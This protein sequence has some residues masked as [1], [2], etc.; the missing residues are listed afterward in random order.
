MIRLPVFGKD[1]L[2]HA[3]SRVIS[4]GV[5]TL[6]WFIFI[7]C[8]IYIGP[9]KNDNVK[10]EVV[11]LMLSPEDHY[12]PNIT[13][14]MIDK[15]GGKAGSEA[16]MAGSEADMAQN[17]PAQERLPAVEQ[18]APVEIPVSNPVQKQ[19][20]PAPV[21]TNNAQKSPAS[22]AKQPVLVP[23]SSAVSQTTSTTSAKT[24]DYAN[25]VD[26]ML[27]TQTANT[28]PKDYSNVDWDAMFGDSSNA[29]TSQ[30]VATTKVQSQNSVSG[31]AATT[32]SPSNPTASSS[33]GT[34][35]SGATNNTASSSTLN[36]LS[37]MA[38]S[39]AAAGSNSSDSSTANA[40][41]SSS[42]KT[43]TGGP[44]EFNDGASRSLKS[45]LKITFS[46]EASKAI[47]ENRD[48]VISFYINEAGNVYNI[49][50]KNSAGIAPIVL[51]EIKTQINKWIF[52][53]APNTSI[54]TFRLKINLQ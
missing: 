9:K 42:Q 32:S 6:F 27:K 37:Q 35:S 4:L 52:D 50:F 47:T 53:S 2:P 54:A 39:N 22:T 40:S 21:N 48:L 44:F 24:Y 17:A 25:S 31:A 41:S 28:K 34:N 15:V 14:E 5:T 10:Y 20:N 46:S 49:S 13:Q 29:Q 26:D 38:N 18:Q 3:S 8:A 19:K 23:E 43:A 12:V 33:S 45:E 1:S 30:S 51:S 11:Q 36:S 16:D 7:I